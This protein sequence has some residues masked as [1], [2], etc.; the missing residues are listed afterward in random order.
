MS[1]SVC[2]PLLAARRVLLPP[3]P[4]RDPKHRER[5]LGYTSHSWR[6][7]NSAPKRRVGKVLYEYTVI[8]NASLVDSVPFVKRVYAGQPI[9]KGY[10]NEACSCG[11][12][13]ARMGTRRGKLSA[14]QLCPV[15]HSSPTFL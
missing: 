11:W 4:I 1:L 9:G 14:K 8:L 15:G 2:Y 5:L 7:L 12:R 13:G 3:K 10:L 6:K